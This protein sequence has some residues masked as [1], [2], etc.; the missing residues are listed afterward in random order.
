MSGMEEP[1]TWERKHPVRK[2][3]EVHVRVTVTKC[4]KLAEGT[5]AA[6]ETSFSLSDTD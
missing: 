4:F 2:E 6:K 1:T 5:V 3:E